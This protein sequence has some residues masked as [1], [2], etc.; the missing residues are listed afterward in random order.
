VDSWSVD[1]G[2][3]PYTFFSKSSLVCCIYAPNRNPDH[4]R[5][6]EEVSDL[7]DPSFPTL[8]VGDFNTG[9]DRSKDR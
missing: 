6:L 2:R 5:F 1:D 3:F 7:V 4:D 8:L 9:F